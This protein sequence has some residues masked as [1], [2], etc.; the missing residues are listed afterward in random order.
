[1]HCPGW[2]SCFRHVIDKN[3]SLRTQLLMN[4]TLQCS[5]AGHFNGKDA[6]TKSFCCPLYYSGYR[7]GQVSIVTHMLQV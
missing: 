5:Q 7:D 4:L 2:R 1:M 3:N 6:L